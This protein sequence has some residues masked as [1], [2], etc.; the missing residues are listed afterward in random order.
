MFNFDSIT[1]E[2][3]EE[4]NPNWPEI[5][6]HPYRTLIVGGAGSEKRNAL[7]NITNSERDI[8]NI[9]LYANNSYEPKYQFLINEG[10]STDL[11]YLIDLK[12]FNEYSNDMD[13]IYNK[14]LN[15]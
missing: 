11:K 10:E 7:C 2:D 14:M 4:H 1:K 8:D 12:P 9:Y 6:N 15:N 3:I 5:A 13:D